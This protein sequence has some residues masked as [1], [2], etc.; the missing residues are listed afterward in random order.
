MASLMLA[1]AVLAQDSADGSDAEPVDDGA[2]DTYGEEVVEDEAVVEDDEEYET[3]V[4]GLISVHKRFYYE[5]SGNDFVLD[6]EVVV[7]K[8]TEMCFMPLP[9]AFCQYGLSNVRTFKD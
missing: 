3:D 7:N 2:A 1:V 6:E 9:D 4:N 8:K 5:L